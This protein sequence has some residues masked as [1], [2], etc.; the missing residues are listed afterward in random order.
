MKSFN[1][2]NPN[3]QIRILKHYLHVVSLLQNPENKDGWNYGTLTEQLNKE[4][5]NDKTVK[6][7]AIRKSMIDK[8]RDDY[9]IDIGVTTG[10]RTIVIENDIDEDTLMKLMQIYCS[11]VTTNSTQEVIIKKFVQKHKRDCLWILAKIYFANIE[12]KY[13]TFTYTNNMNRTYEATVM[14]YYI[15]FRTNNLYLTGFSNRSK[16]MK[17]YVLNRITN[18]ENTELEYTGK[19]P[20]LNEIFKDSLSGFVGNAISVCIEFDGEI[21]ERIEEIIS[22]LEPEIEEKEENI[23]TAKFSISDDQYLCKQLFVFG[24]RIKIIEPKNLKNKM[25]GMLKESLSVYE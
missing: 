17:L 19:I 8:L 9:G 12:N 20:P 23:W 10:G 15:V 18:I 1:S 6:D 16:K 13:I 25:I 21:R 14:P 22:I 3:T 24:N 11:F 5:E 4:Y 2:I 7:D